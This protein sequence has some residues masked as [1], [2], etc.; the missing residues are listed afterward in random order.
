MDRC[1]L[2]RE[3]LR[4]AVRLRRRIGLGRCDPM[5]I[6]DVLEEK[7]H[8]EVKFQA[9]SSMEG[10]YIRKGSKP[11][12]LL[13]SDRPPGRQAYTC[14]H[15]LGHHVFGHGARVDECLDTDQR[16]TAYDPDEW[17]ADRFA[18]FF[19]MPRHAVEK[20]FLT[21]GWHWES[22]QPLQFYIVA[23]QLGVGYESLIQQ[24]RW[25]L[26]M[27]TPSQ[28][29][30]CLAMS[31][32]QLRVALLKRCA[33]SHMLI[34]DRFWDPKVAADLRVGDYAVLPARTL[35]DQQVIR[36]VG[37]C[38]M[39]TVVEATKPG[40]ERVMYSDAADAVNVRV[41][42]NAYAGRSLFR[43]LEDPDYE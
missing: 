25:S 14:A 4:E 21:R 9:L 5:C 42:R 40:T 33:S 22:C 35:P 43:H 23:G 7:L 41:S 29:K 27:L 18:A 12:I 26:G 2:A 38:E 15:E 13:G 32:K 8:I 28:A 19:L 31:P 39:G 37:D 36:I 20:P 11:V 1:E 10:M 16:A 17:L 34:V 6:Y 24:M 3:G 30:A